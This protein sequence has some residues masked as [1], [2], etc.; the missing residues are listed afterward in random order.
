MKQLLDYNFSI[1]FILLIAIGIAPRH[2]PHGDILHGDVRVV[3]VLIGR[4]ELDEPFVLSTYQTRL[5]VN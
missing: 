3:G 2:I 5:E 1:I 4:V